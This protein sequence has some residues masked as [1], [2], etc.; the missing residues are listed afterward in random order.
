ML[1]VKSFFYLRLKFWIFVTDVKFRSLY[2]RDDV[3]LLILHAFSIYFCLYYLK[4]TQ[5]VI[6]FI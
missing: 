6:K 5:W 2:L 4:L 1:V 3:R